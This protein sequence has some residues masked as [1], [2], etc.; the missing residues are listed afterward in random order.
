MQFL[1]NSTTKCKTLKIKLINYLCVIKSVERVTVHN[2]DTEPETDKR[3]FRLFALIS[4]CTFEYWCAVAWQP[5]VDYGIASICLFSVVNGSSSDVVYTANATKLPHACEWTV[6][7]RLCQIHV[8]SMQ[9]TTYSSYFVSAKWDK[10]FI[11]LLSG[12]TWII[13]LFE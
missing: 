9:I 2:S 7:R 3:I 12:F 5:L 6:I 13:Q 8:G 10:L 11:W 1:S 4:N